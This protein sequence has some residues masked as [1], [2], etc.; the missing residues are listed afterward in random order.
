MLR[1]EAFTEELSLRQRERERQ[2]KRER[3]RENEPES[4]RESER[5]TVNLGREA[6][7]PLPD[8]VLQKTLACSD[9]CTPNHCNDNILPGRANQSIKAH[10]GRA[11]IHN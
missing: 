1:N 9:K 6:E 8:W 10:I 2:I 11:I 7:E 3:G 5:E 4:Q